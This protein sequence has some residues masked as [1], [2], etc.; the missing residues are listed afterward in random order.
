MLVK[1]PVWG[2]FMELAF[3]AEADPR[4]KIGKGWSL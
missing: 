4:R 2:V 3:K 1:L